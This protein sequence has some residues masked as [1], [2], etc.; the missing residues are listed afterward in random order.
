MSVIVPQG[1]SASGLLARRNPTVKLAVLFVVSVALLFVLD[2]WTPAVLY[3]LALLGVLSAGRVP[4]RTVAVGHLPFVAFAVG[5]FTVNVLSRPGEILWQLGPARVTAEGLAVGGSLAGRTL[6]IGV[7][8]IGFLATTSGVAL[9][10]SLHQHARLGARVTYAIL[11]GH[12]MLMLLGPEWSTIRHAQAVRSSPAG[13]PALRRRVGALARA[14]FT[15][16]VAAIRRGERVAQSLESRG[17]GLFPRTTW[18]PV[19]IG[20]ADAWFAAAVLGTVAAVLVIA[21]LA[22]QLSGPG[23]LF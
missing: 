7:L 4:V 10:T 22:G 12:R 9:M 8:S 16:L 1:H 11:S 3:V 17:L 15:L 6:V 23:A 5:V 19:P 18:R 20:L 13:R 14:V 21:G 2:P